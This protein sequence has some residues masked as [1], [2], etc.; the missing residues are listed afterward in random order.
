MSATPTPLYQQV[1]HH[2]LGLIADGSL[3]AGARVPSEQDLVHT[4][5]VARMTANRALRELA[6]Q[7]VIVRVAGVGSFVAEEKPRSTL[8]HIANIAEEIRQRGHAHRFALID[9]QAVAASPDV[10]DALGLP[11][12]ARVFHLSGVHFENDIPVQLENRYVNPHVAPDF[13]DQDFGRELPSAWLVRTVPY[14]QIEHVVDAT[15][16]TPEQA[17]WLRMPVNQPCL[18]L[19]RRTWR[20]SAVVTWVHCMHPATRYRLGSRFRTRPGA[21]PTIDASP[22]AVPSAAADTASSHRVAWLEA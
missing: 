5:G 1:K 15:L 4:L 9:M 2:V 21:Q 18:V 3:A 6:A 13:L 14:D 22:D 17:R 8:L 10:A 7:G 19:T 16:P 20:G 11:P 12:Q